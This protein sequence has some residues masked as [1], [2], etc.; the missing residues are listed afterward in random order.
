VWQGLYDE[1]AD[2]GFTVL[3]VALDRSADDARPWIENAAATHPSLVDTEHVIADLYRIINVPT[4][5]WIDERGRIVR[6][7]DAV[8]WTDTFKDMSGI[9]S[10][11]HLEALRA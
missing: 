3:T 4:G 7:N 11:P 1:L 5:L 6:P 9:G 10:G 8:F 2:R